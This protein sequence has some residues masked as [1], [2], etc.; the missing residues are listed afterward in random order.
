MGFNGA[1]WAG[2]MTWWSSGQG[3]V[4]GPDCDIRLAPNRLGSGN[5]YWIQ[6]EPLTH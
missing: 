4:L 5:Y 3:T 2:Y 6:D 1:V